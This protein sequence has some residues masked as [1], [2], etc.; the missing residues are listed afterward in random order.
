MNWTDEDKHEVAEKIVDGMIAEMTLEQ[1]RQYV[2]DDLYDEV[3]THH[4]SYLVDWAEQY[5]PE[6][7]DPQVEFG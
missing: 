4:W 7:L 6:L 3:I 5:A 1:L 2:W